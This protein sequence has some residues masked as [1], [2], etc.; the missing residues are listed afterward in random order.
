MKNRYLYLFGGNPSLME[1]NQDFILRAGGPK[2][3]I[4]LLIMNTTQWE[5]FLPAYTESWHEIG[6]ADYSIIIPNEHSVL[7]HTHTEEILDNATGIYIGGGD[8]YLYHEH[9]ATS[10]IKE[11]IKKRYLEGIPVAGCSAG[12][13]ISLEKSYISP[14]ESMDDGIDYI[15]G[16]GLIDDV[17]IGV[18]YTEEN[19][20]Q[21]LLQAKQRYKVS[22]AYGI[23]EE[24]CVV[25]E[26]ETFMKVIG[27][28][29]HFLD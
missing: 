7:D 15:D 11:M 5:R 19:E 20:R 13:L 23:D 14:N 21:N 22:K 6:I 3:R 28:D 12:A 25:F 17:L 26:N 8:T 24:A 9:Y 1:A 4:A 16:I 27:N 10:P 2:A 29:V 18:H